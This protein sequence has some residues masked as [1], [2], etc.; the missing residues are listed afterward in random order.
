MV[1]LTVTLFFVNDALHDFDNI[2]YP[3]LIYYPEHN[4]PKYSLYNADAAASSKFF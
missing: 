3:E 2:V 4:F 1:V